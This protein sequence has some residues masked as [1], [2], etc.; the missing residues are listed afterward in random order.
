MSRLRSPAGAKT[1]GA[2]LLAAAVLLVV[3]VAPAA[4]APNS[5]LTFTGPNGSAIGFSGTPTVTCGPWESGIRRRTLHI[6]LRNADRA[7]ELRAVLADVAR[8]QRIHFPTDVLA[9]HPRG[10]LFFVYRLSPLIE[11]STNEEEASGSLAFSQASCQPG[12]TV[13]FTVHGRLG[14]ELLEGREVRV[15]GSFTG[16]VG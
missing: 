13:A 3:S 14:S 7:W 15:D 1:L 2:L 12:A 5:E 6:E 9:D 4:E 11:A 10:A 16:V 8:G